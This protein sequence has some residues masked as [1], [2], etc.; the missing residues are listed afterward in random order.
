MKT[1][2][3]EQ[4]EV[5]NG[6]VDLCRVARVATAGGGLGLLLG[7]TMGPVGKAAYLTMITTAIICEYV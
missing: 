4:M 5:L 7:L 3:F 6:G 1:L 2:S